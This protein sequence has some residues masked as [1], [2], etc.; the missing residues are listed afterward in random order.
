[1]FSGPAALTQIEDFAVLSYAQ[2]GTTPA[3]GGGPL[4]TR[5]EGV[6]FRYIAAT[7][8]HELTIPG[9][10]SGV[11]GTPT[12]HGQNPTF[13][14]ETVTEGAGASAFSYDLQLLIPGA[15]NPLL[16]LAYTSYGAWNAGRAQAADPNLIDQN[17]GFF[18]YGVPTPASGVPAAGGAEYSGVVFDGYSTPGSV[19]VTIDFT[20]GRIMGT[21]DA[22]FNDGIGGIGGPGPIAFEGALKPGGSMAEIS[23]PIGTSGRTGSLTIQLTGPHAEELM[24]RW[25]ATVVVPQLGSSP[26]P[27]TVLGAAKRP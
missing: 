5:T 23:F 7:K 8:R 10:G 17:F 24:I 21:V 22:K 9:H 19:T 26:L 20:T 3:N 13:T 27:V 18:T 2:I 14:A 16:P 1:V 6:A 11:L 15:A 25:S 4:E 12:T